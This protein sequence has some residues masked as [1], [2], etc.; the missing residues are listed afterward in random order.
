MGVKEHDIIQK[1]NGKEIH[2]ADDLRKAMAENP[3]ELVLDALHNGKPVK[4]TEEKKV[5]VVEPKKE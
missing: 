2:S 1:L 5:D 3:K 4:L